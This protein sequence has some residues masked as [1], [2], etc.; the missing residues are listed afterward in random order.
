[1]V[2]IVLFL[3]CLSAFAHPGNTD[4]NGGHYNSST[5]LYHHH[6]G[7]PEHQHINGECPYDSWL[8]YALPLLS[9]PCIVLIWFICAS[10]S[11]SLPH[12]IIF[13]LESALLDYKNAIQHTDYCGRMLKEIREKS[14][15]PDGYEIGN[16]GFPKEIDSISWGESL[17]VY[18][19]HDGWKLHLQEDCCGSF[20]VEKNIY[21]FRNKRYSL[22]KKCAEH[23]QVPNM[24]WYAEY[25]KIA[26]YENN[27]LRA[28]EKKDI[29][30]IKLHNCHS[31]C[32]SKMAKFFLVFAPSKKK[33]LNGLKREYN[34]LIQ[35]S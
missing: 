18:T 13:N 27:Y 10:I 11:T 34:N 2:C 21:S 8:P 9:L 29:A 7:M 16:D 22:C 14:T 17:T 19:I 30:L 28:K 6:H 23:Y 3:L 4:S 35:I 12:T 26:P 31:V 15:I 24:E 5:G 33:K 25:L 20:L 32:N 1:M